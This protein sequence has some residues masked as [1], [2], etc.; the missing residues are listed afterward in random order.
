MFPEDNQEG[1]R[2]NM[3]SAQCSELPKTLD[4]SPLPLT[5]FAPRASSL[6]FRPSAYILIRSAT[7][8]GQVHPERPFPANESRSPHLAGFDV[9]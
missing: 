4:D 8:T 3:D 9:S 2:G 7:A 6:S 1:R 5:E